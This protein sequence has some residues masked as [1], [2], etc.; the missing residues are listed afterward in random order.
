M[1]VL[2]IYLF[3]WLFFVVVAAAA[4]AA[5]AIVVAAVR[6][7]IRHYNLI[8]YFSTAVLINVGI[9]L[10]FEV[11]C[12]AQVFFVFFLFFTLTSFFGTAEFGSSR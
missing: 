5:A 3:F 6:C 7:N 11:H 4:A 8:N 10:C 12:A 1:H 9:E 2:F